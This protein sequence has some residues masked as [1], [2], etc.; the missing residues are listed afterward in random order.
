MDRA[1]RAM[2][3]PS[4]LVVPLFLAGLAAPTRGW[5][6]L[7]NGPISPLRGAI[8][9]TRRHP[10]DFDVRHVRV[11]AGDPAATLGTT[12]HGVEFG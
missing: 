4:R 5:Y 12:F 1:E 2:P 6:M 8:L 11:D 3:F 9:L 10:A 7:A